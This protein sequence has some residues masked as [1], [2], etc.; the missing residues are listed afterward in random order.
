MH[1]DFRQRPFIRARGKAVYACCYAS[2]GPEGLHENPIARKGWLPLGNAF[3]VAMGNYAPPVTRALV[4]ARTRRRLVALPGPTK[5]SFETGLIDSQ[6]LCVG[7][8]S[9]VWF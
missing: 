5:L 9:T 3:M 4:T 1:E 7:N 8:K 6:F 2:S